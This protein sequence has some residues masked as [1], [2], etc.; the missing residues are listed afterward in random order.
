[1]CT[2]PIVDPGSFH[3]CIHPSHPF[4]TPQPYEIAS[5]PSPRQGLIFMLMLA[6]ALNP[7][8]PASPPCFPLFTTKLER[9]F[10]ASRNYLFC[11]PKLGCFSFVLFAGLSDSIQP[12]VRVHPHLLF[13]VRAHRCVGRHTRPLAFSF[14][15]T[16]LLRFSTTI[17]PRTISI[18]SLLSVIISG[19]SN[20][21]LRES[22]CA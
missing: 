11:C 4:S 14:P 3:T 22:C 20:V 16:R 1:L 19:A 9:L 8:P 2:R 7:L 18:V 5:F 17:D 15:P 10:A 21:R 13:I 12:P 6:C